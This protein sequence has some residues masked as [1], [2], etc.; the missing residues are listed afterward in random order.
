MYP[1]GTLQIRTQP[2]DSAIDI[3]PSS[4]SRAQTSFPPPPSRQLLYWMTDRGEDIATAQYV[5]MGLYVS[6]IV[7]V[8]SIYRRA[9]GSAMP[10]WSIL[11]VCTSRRWA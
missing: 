3:V 8:L 4:V 10:L 2:S 7:L 5:F 6:L 1:S 9:G 11:L